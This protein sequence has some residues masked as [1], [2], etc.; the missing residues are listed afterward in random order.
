MAYHKQNFTQEFSNLHS[1]TKNTSFRMNGCFFHL[2]SVLTKY[3]N[4]IGRFYLSNENASRQ[5]TC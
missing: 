2:K 1:V 3:C 5:Y 4:V